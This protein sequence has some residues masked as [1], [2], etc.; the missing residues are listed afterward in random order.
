MIDP[1]E[2]KCRC[3]HPKYRHGNVAIRTGDRG[4][5]YSEDVIN[6]TGQCTLRGCSCRY[7]KEKKRKREEVIT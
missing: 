7:Y 3:G 6:Y 5:R 4:G 1:T 2:T